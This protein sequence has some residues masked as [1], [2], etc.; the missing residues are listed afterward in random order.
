[1]PSAFEILDGDELR[2][3]LSDDLGFSL[4]DRARHADRTGRVARMLA[5][6]GVHVIVALVS[7]QARVRDEQR[8]LAWQ[9]NIRFAEVYLTADRSRVIQRDTKGLYRRA[10][11][12]EIPAFTGV[13]APYE[14]PLNPELTIRTDELSPEQSSSALEAWL[15]TAGWWSEFS[16]AAC[17]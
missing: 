14:P 12:G 5:R 16:R 11:S 1:M 9:N 10:Y 3:W 6:H 8:K 13:S 15:R 17:R 7:P 4:D 2:T